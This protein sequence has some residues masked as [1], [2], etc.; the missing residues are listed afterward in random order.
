MASK[1]LGL[2]ILAVGL[3]G[4]SGSSD[5]LVLLPDNLRAEVAAQRAAEAQA[6]PGLAS[7]ELKPSVISD[8]VAEAPRAEAKMSVDAG[9]SAPPPGPVGAMPSQRSLGAA[10]PANPSA[11]PPKGMTVQDILA[12]ARTAEAAP[13]RGGPFIPAP[14]S[15]APGPG[16][17]PEPPA[18]DGEEALR[19]RL[20]P[21]TAIAQAT[22][23]AA[24]PTQLANIPRAPATEKR[25]ID[26]GL[27][28]AF[29][30]GA[31]TL[32]PAEQMKVALTT[33]N[34]GLPS[35]GRVTLLLGPASSESSLERFRV[36]RQRGE[37]VAALLPHGSEIVQDYR[38]EL[39]EDAVW[40]VFGE[41]YASEA[42]R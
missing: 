17:G 30:R 5:P 36:A 1:R 29:S 28:V 24:A 2:L 18:D 34:A 42:K 15:V 23:K 32:S 16:S 35:G 20:A 39:P 6:K 12:R 10:T 41:R 40:I 37:V 4:C 22:N 31:T 14:A 38:P 27:K 9:T 3:A 33:A 13:P 26:P 11:P 7:A 25:P 8:A 19:P 21:A